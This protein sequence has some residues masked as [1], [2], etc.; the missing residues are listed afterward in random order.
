[1]STFLLRI[2]LA[3][4]TAIVVPLGDL[5]WRLE[6]SRARLRTILENRTASNDHP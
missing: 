2:R 3:V 5:F 4:L 6:T 1:M